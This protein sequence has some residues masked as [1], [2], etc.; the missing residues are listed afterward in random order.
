MG[1]AFLHI[2]P[3]AMAMLFAAAAAVC[4]LRSRRIPNRLVLLCFVVALLTQRLVAGWRG[5]AGAAA[6]T[7]IALTIMSVPFLLGGMGAGDVKLMGAVAAFSGLPTLTLLLTATALAGG[8]FGLLV[9]GRKLWAN[10]QRLRSQGRGEIA[11]SPDTLPYA[12]AIACGVLAVFCH[13]LRGLA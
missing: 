4:D 1:R 12:L 9:I 10:R 5:V 2:L 11:A 13:A 6:A 3:Y 8:G 7:A